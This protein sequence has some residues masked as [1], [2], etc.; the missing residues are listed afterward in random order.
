MVGDDFQRSLA[1]VGAA[2]GLGRGIQQAAQDI[3]A[4]I[5]ELWDFVSGKGVGTALSKIG[6]EL[7]EAATLLAEDLF[8]DTKR[9]ELRRP[10]SREAAAA[11]ALSFGAV[12]P[13]LALPPGVGVTDARTQSVTVNVG[14]TA[15]VAG[16]VS[17]A[18]QGLGRD[19]AA[20][21]AAVGG[22]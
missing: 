1:F 5:K 7:S 19:A 3:L 8:S 9:G 6:G 18:T 17:G 4:A 15:E 11:G 10:V 21:L 2:D 22:S 12:A 20:D 13:G 16:A 14:S